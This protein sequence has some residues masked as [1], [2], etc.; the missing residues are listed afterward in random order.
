VS[1]WL[2][3]LLGLSA[4]AVAAESTDRSAASPNFLV[5]LL[6]DVGFGATS[7][8]GGPVPTPTLDRLAAEGLR[9]NRFHTTG[10]CSPTRAS[11]LTGRNPHAV[12]VGAVLNSVTARPG[13]EGVLR[14]SAATIAE[15]LRQNGYATALFGKWHLTPDWES[16]GAGPFDRWPARQGFEKFY[17]FL[18]GETDQYE[19]TL[20]EGTAQVQR[21]PRA[22]YHLSED[23]ADQAIAWIGEQR[24]LRPERPFLVYLAPGATHAPLQVPR[25]WRERFRGRFDAGWDALREQILARQ[26]QLGVVPRDAQLAEKSGEIPAW[27]SLSEEERRVAARLME[28]YAGFLA[29]VDAE[30]GRVIDALVEQG[31]RDDTVVVYIAGDNGASGEGGLGGALSYMGRIQ[32]IDGGTRAL[33]ARIDALGD[34]T[35]YP[36]YPAGFALALDTPFPWLKQ[37]ASHLG[38]TRTGMVISWPAGIRERGGLRSQFA[39]V[40]DIAPT[41]LEVAGIAAPAHVNGVAQQP[42]D[43]T[44]LV[45]SFADARAADRHRTQY[46]EIFGNRAIYHDGWIASAYHG[47]PPWRLLLP[48]GQRDFDRDAWELYDLGRD[49]SQSRDVSAEHPEKLRELQRLF[50][51]EA[52]KNGVLPLHESGDR[53]GLPS[54]FGSRRRFRLA[55]GTGIP[56]PAAPELVNR[57]FELRARIAVPAAGAKGV[58]AA[59]GGNA[60]GFAL[61]VDAQ[62]RPA[63]VYEL[64][65]VERAQLV[66]RRALGPGEAEVSLVFDYAGGGPG[67]GAKL[68][69][70]VDGKSVATGSIS[71]SAP[72]F[73]TIDERLDVGTDSGSPVGDYPANDRFT[74]E[75]REL[76]IDLR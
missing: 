20:F 12:G 67:R 73:F 34:A 4:A 17:G 42:L 18:G 1:K 64:F 7:T 16:S 14:P 68:D 61:Y 59:I 47:R 69:L 2:G 54:L 25:A 9:Y 76:E 44:S 63:F 72:S 65:D 58:L 49:F 37:V 6:D 39:H 52:A 48:E 62:G 8:F 24:A 28:L 10:I 23:L 41:L 21:P 5:V 57:S 60:A 55:R 15:V 32:G 50:E 71:R 33:A 46:F 31:I 40:N 30:I 38:A 27:E 70:R 56:E 36:H 45:Y 11:L 74:G 19:P 66:G 3:A 29:H 22:D 53:R 51:A 35:T 75:I 13:Y 43:G 26:K